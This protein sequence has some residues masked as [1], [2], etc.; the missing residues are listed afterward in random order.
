MNYK[1]VFQ[2]A[3]DKGYRNY[4]SDIF[5][6][7]YTAGTRNE[8]YSDLEIEA[9]V[10]EVEN[11]LELTLIQ[12]W[13]RG[14]HKIGVHLDLQFNGYGYCWLLYDLSLKQDRT[15]TFSKIYFNT[16]EQALLEGITEALKLI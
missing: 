1:E 4:L 7:Q 8:G 13:L 16:Y 5:A 12:K 6:E 2:L 14:E 11:L 9:E 15:I 10:K 3:Q